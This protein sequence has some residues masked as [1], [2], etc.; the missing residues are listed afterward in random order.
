MKLLIVE[1]EKILSDSIRSYLTQENFVCEVAD[2]YSN[3][4]DKIELY[5]YDCILL[6]INLQ[7]G[8]GLD[9]LK[10][11]KINRKSDG[12]LIISARHSLEDKVAGLQLGADDYL[13]KPFHLSE[14]GARVAAIIRRR[15]SAGNNLIRLEEVLIDT[16]ARTVIV[17]G[18]TLDLTR[19]EYQLLLYFAYNKGRVVSKNAIAEHL[20]GDDTGGAA[21]HDF[22]YTHIKNLRRKMLEAGARDPI[23]SVYGVGYKLTLS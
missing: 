18:R 14:L 15:H 11:L 7:D 19:K 3:A 5:D 8:N 20:W 6:D 23:Q 10:E 22:I 12:V 1:D 17:E 4:L 13:S 21:S 2:S 9:L 16:Q